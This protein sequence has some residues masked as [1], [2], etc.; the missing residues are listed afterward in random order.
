MLERKG[1]MAMPVTVAAR[2][3]DGTEQRRRT[4]RLPNRQVLHVTASSRIREVVIDP[5]GALAMAEPP[6]EP[7]RTLQSRVSDLPWTGAGDQAVRLFGDASSL[8]VSEERIWVKL[9]LTL[10]DGGHYEKSM[11]ALAHIE[12]NFLRLVW[13]GNN[14][15]MLGR[16]ADAVDRYRRALS[17]SEKPTLKHDQYGLTIDEAWV[18]ERVATP[19]VRK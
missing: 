6:S 8:A 9:A 7:V 1:T 12:P 14:L 17:L 2:F 4:D 19:F 3:E 13:E 11:E 18:R 15:D 16:R 5:D 10:F